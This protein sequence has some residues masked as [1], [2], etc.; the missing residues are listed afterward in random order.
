MTMNHPEAVAILRALTEQ[1]R[2][3]LEAVYRSILLDALNLPDEQ[4]LWWADLTSP[5][6]FADAFTEVE[7]QC[8]LAAVEALWLDLGLEHG[9]PQP[10]D[11]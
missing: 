2:R 11:G 8:W 1:H 10:E 9:F 5:S 4:R 6:T 3:E 7:V